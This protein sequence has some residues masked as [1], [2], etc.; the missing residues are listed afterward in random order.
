MPHAFTAVG[1]ERAIVYARGDDA[2]P[3]PRRLYASMGFSVRPRSH[4]YA[5]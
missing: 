1:A 4:T 3:V 5:R 2:Y